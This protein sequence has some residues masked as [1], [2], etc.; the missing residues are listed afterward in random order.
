MPEQQSQNNACL[1][2]CARSPTGGRHEIAQNRHHRAWNWMEVGATGNFLCGGTIIVWSGAHRAEPDQVGSALQSAA[3]TGAGCTDARQNPNSRRQRSVDLKNAAERE[4]GRPSGRVVGGSSAVRRTVR[5]PMRANQHLD[6]STRG[7]RLT[8]HEDELPQRDGPQASVR[9]KLVEIAALLLKMN[10][11]D[12]SMWAQSRILECATRGERE[13]AMPA[14]TTAVRGAHLSQSHSAQT[15]PMA[16][17][18]ALC[19]PLPRGV[20]YVCGRYVLPAVLL[21]VL[22]FE[23]LGLAHRKLGLSRGVC[24]RRRRRPRAKRPRIERAQ[25]QTQSPVIGVLP[26]RWRIRCGTARSPSPRRPRPSRCPGTRSPSLKRLPLRSSSMA[27]KRCPAP[28]RPAHATARERTRDPTPI[29]T[30]ARARASRTP[31]SHEAPEM[32]LQLVGKGAGGGHTRPRGV[33]L[34][35]QCLAPPPNCLVLNGGPVACGAAKFRVRPLAAALG[36]EVVILPQAR[37]GSNS[38]ESN[39]L[40]RQRAPLQTRRGLRPWWR[41]SRARGNRR[42]PERAPHAPA[43]STTATGPARPR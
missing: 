19:V 3:S 11:G 30:R 29:Q 1:R 6:D 8:G 37:L 35:T 25:F 22:R 32:L 38:G 17:N 40:G 34:R 4:L 31:S 24:R 5:R 28:T 20:L 7:R 39:P 16:V 27:A 41:R 15:S 26:K 12:K 42:W 18:L 33:R 14:A 21:A 2:K 23:R 36:H 9:G 10:H 43:A 13:L